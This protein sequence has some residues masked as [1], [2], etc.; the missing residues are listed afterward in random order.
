MLRIFTATAVLCCLTLTVHA[1]THAA[2][3]T[4]KSDMCAT[5]GAYSDVLVKSR[6][7]GIPPMKAMA[8]ID[9]QE[10]KKPDQKA[11]MAFLRWIVIEVY[12]Y[13]SL[14]GAWLRQRVEVK[15][16]EHPF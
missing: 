10:R 4:T 2:V 9:Q 15:C 6:D 5:V 1:A 11:A 16:F 14:D 13:P 7:R 3:P 8:I 12:K